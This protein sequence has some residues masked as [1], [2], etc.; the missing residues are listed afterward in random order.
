MKES[1]PP[2]RLILLASAQSY[3][4]K[5]FEKG[6]NANPTGRPKGSR[7]KLGEDFIKDL[8]VHWTENGTQALTDC[9]KHSP[10]QYVKVV[11]SLLPKQIDMKLDNPLA[12]LSDDQVA[13]VVRLARS[14]A[15]AGDGAHKETGQKQSGSVH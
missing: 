14:I 7:N 13:D 9:L 11:A 3:R 12:D 8:L 1:A 2:K 10:S 5:P 4:G 6:N 15:S